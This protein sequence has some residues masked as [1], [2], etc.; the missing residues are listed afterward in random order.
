[1]PVDCH[2]VWRV[3]DDV[4]YHGVPFPRFDHWTGYSSVHGG[5][6]YVPPVG[7]FLVPIMSQP[8]NFDDTIC[9]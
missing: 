5:N 1:M 6:V 8:E 9:I 2:I 7:M 4:D 3:V